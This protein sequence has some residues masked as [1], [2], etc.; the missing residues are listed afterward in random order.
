MKKYNSYLIRLL[1]IFL[2]I[3]GCDAPHSNPLDPLNKKSELLVISGYVYTFSLPRIPIQNAY[4]IWAPE[5]KAF[6][7][8]SNG[9]FKINVERPVS[10]WLKVHHANFKTDSLY[11]DFNNKK[12]VYEFYLNQIPIVDSLELYTILL[13]QYPNL[14]TASLATRIKINDRDNDIDS[15][16]IENSKD[17]KVY[18]LFYNTQTKFF[19]RSFSE[20]DLD[21]EDLDE[22]VGV[23]FR[24]VVKDL[25]K[26]KFVVAEDKINR[27][28]KSEISLEYPVNYD[29][30]SN[31][32]LLVWRRISPGF[33]HN[34]SVE[35]LSSDFP[36]VV[37]WFKHNLDMESSSVQTDIPLQ[38]GTYYWVVWCI[39]Q[40]LNR[41]RSKPATFV[42][43]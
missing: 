43:K 6:V 5:N 42:V 37:V 39:D 16:F 36:P 17:G 33:K 9:Y 4:I 22:L 23:K 18:S 32:P 24:Y 12:L 31:R 3:W 14:Q 1:F 2:L 40:F 34:Y 30:I 11:V 10:G 38:P 25:S 8:N 41:A 29:T 20:Y 15:V 7:S 21:V 27:I 26:M 35:I 28:I 19:E 13:N